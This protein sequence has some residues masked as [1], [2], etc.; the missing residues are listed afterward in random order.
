MPCSGQ[1]Y[2]I[3]GSVVLAGSLLDGQVVS[4]HVIRIASE[5]EAKVRAGYLLFALTHP[6]YGRPLVKALAFG[7]SVPELD[8]A[9]ISEF[10]VV[11]LTQGAEVTIADLADESAAERALAD[12]LERGLAADAGN[13]VERF[14]AGDLENFIAVRSTGNAGAGEE[15]S[16]KN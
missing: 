15:A 16:S 11:R 7:S 8:P 5:T 4:N 9:E 1:V 10:T 2:G 13:L 3:I 6:V 12:V 14:I